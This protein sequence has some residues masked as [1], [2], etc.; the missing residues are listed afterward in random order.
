VLYNPAAVDQAANQTIEG[1]QKIGATDMEMVGRAAGSLLG[2][3]EADAAAAYPGMIADLQRQGFARYAPPDYPGH[4]AVQGLVQRGLTVPQQYETGLLTA[5]GVTDALRAASAPLPGTGA[6]GGGGSG[7]GTYAPGTPF[8]PKMLPSGVSL[9]E[10]AMV[11]TIAGEAGSEPLSGQIGVAHVIANRAKG[12][13]VSPRDVVFSPNQFEPWNGGAARQRLEAM[14]PTSPSY[15]AILNNVVRPVMAGSA[16]DPTGGATHFYAPVAQSDLGR[17]APSWGQGTPSAVIGGHRFY[18]LG[19]GPGQAQAGG[20]APAPQ[21]APA[22]FNPNAGPR[23]AGAPPAG[24]PGPAATPGFV[25]LTPVP[26]APTVTGQADV[27]APV[28]PSPVAL[29]TGGTDVAGPG[30]GPDTTLPSVAQPNQLYQTGL[31]GVTISGP[32]S[33][34]L[35]P[36]AAAAPAAPVA[37]APAAVPAPPA[38]RPATGQ[39]S[40]QFQA[41]MELN[42]RAQAL[43][44]VVDPTGRTKAL[45]A[46]LR[47]QAALYMQADSVSYD[48]NTGI[49]TKAITGERVSAPT[50]AEHWVQNPDGT[51]TNTSTGKREYPPT[52][53]QFTDAQGNNWIVLPGGSVKQVTSNPSGV[54]GSGDDASALRILNEVGPKMANGTATPQ[55]AANYST[56]A[57]IYRKPALQVDPVS[58]QTVKIY[59]RD[60]PAGFPDPANPTGGGG[61]GAGGGPKVVLPGLS[62]AQ[63]QVERDPAAYKV[64]ESQY[65]RDS[66][67]VGAIGDAGR[68]AQADQ[69][70][71][72]EMQDVLQRFSTGPGTEWRTAASAWLQRWLP[73]EVT[74]WEKESATLSGADAAQAF[75]KLALVG[76]GTQERGVLGARGGYQAIK[77]FKDANPGVNL[78]DA[79]NKSILDMQMITNQA[80]QDYSQAALSH[81]ADNETKFGQTHQYASLAQF[82]RAWNAQRNPQVYAGAMGAVSGQ[83][84]SQWAKG[85]SEDEYKRALDIVSRANPS[86][87]VNGKSGRISMQPQAGQGAGAGTPVSVKTPAEAAALPAG[88][89]YTTPDGKTFVR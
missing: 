26:G 58:K 55:E 57:E 34:A 88:T 21:P 65:D 86:A 9:D 1:R 47:A 4:A 35:A 10:D 78:Q 66:K 56:A 48:P 15:Q 77:L 16:P 23:V 24:A 49:G 36:P 11:R 53:R 62:P 8:T 69:V 74:G 18:K 13:G 70:R 51:L 75:S 46:S 63:Q 89:Q 87:T 45:A 31:P 82:D 7:G 3:S 32:A 80:N 30:A 29:R 81:F 28:T 5:P 25:P 50:P 27:P 17:N 14:D 19:Y 64:A 33:N 41:A 79:T 12:A 6:G 37:Q 83:P 44:L 42:R 39:N 38:A 22:A 54:T 43:D 61:P 60:L 2:M 52:G 20:T 76:A 59:T 84:A 40:P 67:E 73:K 72:K 71:I 68:Q 85:L